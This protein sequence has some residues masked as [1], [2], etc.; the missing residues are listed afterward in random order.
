MIDIIPAIFE[1]NWDEIVKKV[2]LVAHD[3]DWVQIDIADGTLVP[4]ETFLDFAKLGKFGQLG[5]SLSLEAHLMVA[6]P[7]KYIRPLV[8][9]GF[10]RIIAQVE[11]NDP[12]LFLDEIDRESVEVGLAIDGPTPLEQIAPFLENLDVVLVMMAEMGATGLVLQSE[13]VEKIRAIHQ[14]YPD[15]A[16]EAEEGIDEHTAKVIV[17][18]GA[19]R[20]V[21]TKFLFSDVKNIATAIDQLKKF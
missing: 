13:N 4:A 11:C 2:E 10:K 15:L 20:A 17:E 18:A 16:I 12:R 9:A 8:E 3:V 14:S 6:S 19:T 7:E 5:K 1:K 21:V